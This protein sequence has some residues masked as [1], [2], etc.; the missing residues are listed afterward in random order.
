MQFIS[1]CFYI[2]SPTKQTKP[3]MVCGERGDRFWLRL[4]LKSRITLLSHAP[5]ATGI[6][7]KQYLILEYYNLQDNNLQDNKTT[8]SDARPISVSSV[9]N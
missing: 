7:I 4:E 5:A 3:L 8:L 1:E 9:F 6:A 2:Q